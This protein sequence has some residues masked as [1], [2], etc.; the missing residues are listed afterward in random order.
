MQIVD[1]TVAH[2]EQAAQIAKQN[3]EEERGVVPALPPIDAVPDL[4]PYVKNGLGVAAF[5]GD[6]MLGFLCAVGPFP[7]AFRSTD[8]VDPVVKRKFNEYTVNQIL[9]G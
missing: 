7:N 2:I 5:D 6:T 1:F 3:Y 9:L 8:K 4:T